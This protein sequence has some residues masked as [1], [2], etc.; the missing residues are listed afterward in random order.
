MRQLTAIAVTLILLFFARSVFANSELPDLEPEL[1]PTYSLDIDDQIEKRKARIEYIVRELTPEEQEKR[2]LAM[3]VQDG[4]S[5]KLIRR[6][7][8]KVS[9]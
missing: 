7:S 1:D 9:K 8:Q 6:P 2:Q 4:L 5:L 3:Q